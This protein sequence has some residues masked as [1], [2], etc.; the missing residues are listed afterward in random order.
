[1]TLYGHERV[2]KWIFMLVALLQPLIVFG[3][4]YQTFLLGQ[5]LLDWSVRLL[6]L[7]ITVWIRYWLLSSH[8]S[9][10]LRR[11]LQIFCPVA[12]LTLTTGSWL[13]ADELVAGLRVMD[14]LINGMLIAYIFENL[15]A[16][17]GWAMAVLPR[18]RVSEARFAERSRFLRRSVALLR[19]V[20]FGLTLMTLLALYTLSRS[21]LF[22][23]VLYSRIAAGIV[24]FGFVISLVMLHFNVRRKAEEELN[25]VEREIE[26]A[27]DRILAWK[28]PGQESKVDPQILVF[29]Q[30]YRE[31]LISSIKT[32]LSWET[33][34]VILL[35]AA[36][37]LIEP[38][39]AGIFLI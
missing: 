23:W 36:I 24:L 27:L 22:D 35:F 21:F 38:Y 25:L 14:A 3:W 37:I 6:L 7:G 4:N 13:K 1:M 30:A 34:A 11:V 18:G 29:W 12:A 33:C 9:T 26:T 39:V 28:P 20:F 10:R 15:I 17:L 8:R 16:A 19:N 32:P 31:L 2:E 5:V